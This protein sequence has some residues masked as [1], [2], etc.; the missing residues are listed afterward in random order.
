MSSRRYVAFISYSHKDAEWANWLHKSLESYRIPSKLVRSDSDRTI[1][2]RLAPIFKDRDELPA[3]SSLSERIKD[4]ISDSDAMIV[5]CSPDAAQSRFVHE[6]I[7]TYK[8]LGKAKTL[9]PL[10]VGGEPNSDE[11]ECFPQSLK[12]KLDSN[13]NLSD[14]LDEPIAAD[15]RPGKDSRNAAKLKIIAGLLGV[16]F[17]D[18]RQREARKRLKL[19]SGITATALAVM[20]VTITLAIS[21]YYSK[22]EAQRRGAQ[23]EDL[24]DFMLEDLRARLEP[25]GK[26]ELLD[27]V[28]DKAMAYFASL[29]ASDVDEATLV[30]HATALRQIGEVRSTQGHSAEAL[31]AFNESLRLLET[32]GPDTENLDLLYQLGRTRFGIADV[33]YNRLE[34]A[35]T[36][37]QIRHYRDLAAR[38]VEIDPT[39]VKSRMELAFTENNLGS[40]AVRINQPE[41]AR[42]RFMA[43]LEIKQKLLDEDPGNPEFKA[44]LADT[45][46][47][48]GTVELKAGNILKAIERHRREVELRMSLVRQE[49]DVR[50]RD[51]LGIAFIRLSDDLYQ[52]GRTEEAGGY[53]RQ[54]VSI[55]RG[56]VDHDPENAVWCCELHSSLLRQARIQLSIGEV[57]GTAALVRE[58][59]EGIDAALETNPS[60]GRLLRERA[61]AG[62]HLARILMIEGRP[63][64]AREK[65]QDGMARLRSLI[66]AGRADVEVYKEFARAAYV[67]A[68]A[69]AAS[70]STGGAIA[71]EV[72]REALVVLENFDDNETETAAL[73]AMLLMLAGRQN[74]ARQV[75]DRVPATDYRAPEALY[76]SVLSRTIYSD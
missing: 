31:E 63:D 18:L 35:Q 72:A 56:L 42:P 21:A 46:S 66:H 70:D 6:E 8:R 62:L 33:Y 29:T 22:Q 52:L 38:M 28:G 53:A 60:D 50:S 24:I 34:Y 74:E 64:Q 67:A 20:L 5:I 43:A 3:S 27:A 30:G 69:C 61:I 65:A 54:S 32:A 13:G 68:E 26:L 23:A 19:M 11:D 59:M 25:L 41:L 39:S 15:A 49:F 47:W 76:G 7:L 17:N 73:R 12:Y 58:A 10:I 45:I 57:E 40:L 9:L 44:E 51:K 75:M 48:I 71:S 2:K 14:E 16:G 36:R 37:E 4:A 55:Y 1:P